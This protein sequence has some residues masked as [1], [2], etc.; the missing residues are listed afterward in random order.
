[1]LMTDM[2]V[3]CSGCEGTLLLLPFLLR[4]AGRVLLCRLKERNCPASGERAGRGSSRSTPVVL[5]VDS[6][7]RQAGERASSRPSPHNHGLT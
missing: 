6:A 2:R 3:I 1:M 7:E 4:S 5:S